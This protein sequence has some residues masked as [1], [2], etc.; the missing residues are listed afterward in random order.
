MRIIS[1]IRSNIFKKNYL[2]IANTLFWRTKFSMDFSSIKNHLQNTLC[3][4]I[5]Y[6]G[7]YI[8]LVKVLGIKCLIIDKF[9][10]LMVINLIKTGK[11]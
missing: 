8:N 3:S 4:F 1:T 9:H 7:I 11:Q 5:V 10:V 2:S 6:T